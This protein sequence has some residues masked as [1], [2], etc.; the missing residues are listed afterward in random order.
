MLRKNDND[1]KIMKN[2]SKSKKWFI[3]FCAPTI[4]IVSLVTFLFD[5]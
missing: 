4:Y 5:I 2:D 1:I 3:K